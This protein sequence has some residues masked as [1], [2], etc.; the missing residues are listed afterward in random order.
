MR[1]NLY[2]VKVVKSG[3]F[4]VTAGAIGLAGFLQCTRDNPID[5]GSD[6]YIPGSAPLAGFAADTVQCLAT[7]PVQIT[8]SFSDTQALGGK[9]PA[10]TTLYFNWNGNSDS[11]TDSVTVTAASPVVISRVFNLVRNVSAYVRARDND[12]L[13]RV[14]QFRRI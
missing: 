11:L 14:K 8:V 3:V 12:G 5:P 1:G 6:D 9:T 10:V 2:A 13:P 4:F 7:D